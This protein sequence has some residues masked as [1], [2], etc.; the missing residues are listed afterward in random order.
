MMDSLILLAIVG[1]IA[2]FI[3]MQVVHG[4]QIINQSKTEEGI[5][6][7]GNVPM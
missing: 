4:G 7:A 3:T 2:V 1:I 6:L 5:E